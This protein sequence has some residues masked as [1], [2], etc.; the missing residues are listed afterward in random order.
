VRDALNDYQY[1]HPSG[2]WVQNPANIIAVGDPSSALS[3]RVRVAHSGSIT[4]FY[5]EVPHVHSS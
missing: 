3:L 4:D 2:A 5:E 1:V